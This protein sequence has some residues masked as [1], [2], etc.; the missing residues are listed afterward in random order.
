M[1]EGLKKCG[2]RVIV[3]NLVLKQIHLSTDEVIK[4]RNIKKM[5]SH[6]TLLQ[7]LR[8]T[9]QCIYVFE[10][11]ARY[12]RCMKYRKLLSSSFFHDPRL[13]EIGS[14]Y[15]FMQCSTLTVDWF[16]DLIACVYQFIISNHH[17]RLSLYVAWKV[18]HDDEGST[19][20]LELDKTDE[21]YHSFVEK[22]LLGR[23]RHIGVLSPIEQNYRFASVNH[24]AYTWFLHCC[25]T[26][27]KKDKK[28]PVERLH[29]FI[30]SWFQPF[31]GCETVSKIKRPKYVFQ[32]I[33]YS[34]LLQSESLS[35]A[36]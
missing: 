14:Y 8:C 10:P 6:L 29:Y 4:S 23:L 28:S 11:F 7:A 36:S 16:V 26:A 25:S 31:P 15:T 3:L 18:H 33:S 9:C 12:C 20:Y 27:G 19:S 5:I 1:E 22:K 2:N 21:K 35:S 17:E 34:A 30:H 24:T 13:I 32:Y